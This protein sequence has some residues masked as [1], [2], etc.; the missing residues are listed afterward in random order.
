MTRVGCIG[1]GY[2]ARFQISAWARMQGVQVLAVGDT[3][4]QARAAG[5]ALAPGATP[6]ADIEAVLALGP[7]IVDIATPPSTHAT[8]I[9]ACLGKVVTVICQKP[10]CAD[11]EEARAIAAQAEAAGTRLI[12]HENFR[13]QP[14]YREIASLMAQGRLGDVRQARFALRPGD[15]LGREA[16]LDRQPYFRDMPRFLIRETGIH[17]IDVFRYLFGPPHVVYADLRT[18][19]DVIAGEDAG[20]VIFDMPQGARAVFD[21]NRTLDHAA[22]NTR[23]TM[24]EMSVE[25]LD[26][27]LRLT[28]DGALHLRARDAVEWQQHDYRFEDRDFGGNCVERFQAHVLQALAGKGGFETLAQAYLQN[29]EVEAAI[30][31]SAAEGQRMPTGQ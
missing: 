14:W 6:V 25:G 12:I 11:L 15:G 9:S 2:F 5:A 13:F 16:Y 20:L 4:P 22:Q 7:D 10:F 30:Y 17:F 23:L 28:G 19:N 31:R 18:E 1:A 26:A 27:E 24:G 29:L 21:G 3:N 8:L